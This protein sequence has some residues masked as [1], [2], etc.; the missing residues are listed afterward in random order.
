MDGTP[1]A[2]VLLITRNGLPI[3]RRVLE[4]V[5]R[6]ETDWPYE[7][8]AV[9]SGSSDGTVEALHA[10]GVRVV[11]ISPSEFGHGR[12]RNHAASLARGEYLVFLVQDAIPAD[13]FWLSRLVDACRVADVAGA[14]SRQLPRPDSALLTHYL[15]LGTTP[16]N[17]ERQVK[18]LPPDTALSSLEA[19][20]R[21]QLALFQNASSCIRRDVWEVHRFADLPYGE[22]I[23]WG[24]QVVEAGHAIVYEAGSTVHH[25]HDRSAMYAMKRAYA[26]HRQAYHLFGLRMVPSVLSMLRYA[27]WSIIDA[28]RWLW[29]RPEPTSGR[30][31]AMARVPLYVSAR[32]FG[33]WLGPSL[34]NA[35]RSA[36]AQGLDA[37]LRSGV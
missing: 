5:Q 24:R 2:S 6:Q 23:D 18:R 3:L 8:I 26:D 15:T 37:T 27:G 29:Q 17:P 28:W 7:V 10:A 19:H 4:A 16:V 13:E 12:T 22:D 36:W 35:G 32:A 20:S 30:L 9:D 1:G 34:E 14:Y 31:L 21:F 11:S 33:A 25:S